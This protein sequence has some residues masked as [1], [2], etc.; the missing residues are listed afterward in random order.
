MGQRIW[1]VLEEY[2]G[3]WVAVDKLGR[4]V[5]SAEN[6]SELKGRVGTQAGTLTFIFAAHA[7][8]AV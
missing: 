7:S 1:A 3:R 4:V 2:A 6:L 8:V 5:D